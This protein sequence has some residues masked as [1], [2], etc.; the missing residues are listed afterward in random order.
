MATR[1]SPGAKKRT[2]KR[3]EPVVI[4]WREW[5]DLP[6]LGV[7]GVKAKIDTGAR[8]SALHAIGLVELDGGDRV[9]FDIRPRQRT[10]VGMATVECDVVDRRHIRSSN[11]RTEVRPVIRTQLQLAGVTKTIELTLTNRDEMG[12]RMLIGRQA[13]RRHFMIDPATSF[14]GAEAP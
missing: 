2:R 8:T 12:F 6:D 4:G 9:R 3:I 7:T 1:K 11:G 14:R 10:R 13:L 5:V